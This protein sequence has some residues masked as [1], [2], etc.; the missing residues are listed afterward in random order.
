MKLSSALFLRLCATLLVG[1]LPAIA[2]LHA[3]S[4]NEIP[5]KMQALVDQ[6]QVSGVVTL[7]A[8]KDQI[9]HCEAVGKSDLAS[10]RDMRKDDIFWIASMSKPITA[11][12]VAMLADE[13]K[14]R[15]DDPVE[16]YLPEFGKQ[17]LVVESTPDRRVLGRP[18]H[19]ITLR[20]LL[21]H[22]SGLGEYVVTD[23]H[24]TLSEMTKVIAREPLR[25][26]PGSRWGYSTAGID[27]LGRVVEVVSGQ[28]FAQFVQQRIFDPLGMKDSTFW[29]TPEQAQRFATNYRLNPDTG[30]LEPAVIAYM[31]G[32]AVTD[33]ARPALGGAGIFSTAQDVAK[34]YQMMLRGGEL[35]GKRLLQP[36]TVTEL[37]R[38]QT[39]ELA[40][41]PGMTWGLGF[42]T[43]RD[44]KAMEAN[45]ALTAGSFGHG[46]AHGTNSW[47]DPT[48][49]VIYIIMLQRAGLRNP[50][51]SDMRRIFQE[52]AA[53]SFRE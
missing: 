34:F 24:W 49:G 32:G 14:L 33:H 15:Y 6:G 1:A 7:V 17:S 29:L 18:A 43:V 3:A 31:Y 40:T 5:G 2:P 35:G 47:A 20:E 13:G 21:T 12:A 22:T 27:T 9:L 41:R 11:V 51:N 4:F 37:T 38:N 19:P 48:R 28:P 52:T 44:P 36:A 42:C 45:G 53:A 26:A 39:G 30:K 25:F 16:K 23:P 50:D 8:T 46:G 10:G